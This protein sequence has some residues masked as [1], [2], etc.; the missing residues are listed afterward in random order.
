MSDKDSEILKLYEEN[1]NLK[2]ENKELNQ[3]LGFSME[4][5]NKL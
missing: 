3:T 4:Q 2:K 5:V 1:E